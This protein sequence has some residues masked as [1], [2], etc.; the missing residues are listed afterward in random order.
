M[1]CDDYGPDL[2]ASLLG[3][4]DADAA[5]GLAE[6]L[7]LC[8]ACSAEA[9]RCAAL[10]EAAG[11]LVEPAPEAGSLDAIRAAIDE[12]ERVGTLLTALAL[13]QL[14]GA[15]LA[16]AQALVAGDGAARLEFDAI[17][18]LAEGSRS[19]EAPVP[20]PRVLARLK[21]ALRDEAD[22][23][24]GDDDA[25]D[26]DARRAAPSPV[27]R[28]GRSSR[29]LRLVL[30]LVAAAALIV[31]AVILPGEAARSAIVIKGQLLIRPASGSA[32]DDWA[33]ATK[34]AVR[35]RVGDELQA[36]DGPVEL[37][38]RCDGG[39]A[40]SATVDQHPADTVVDLRLGPGARLHRT[41]AREF[42]LTAGGV[43][44]HAGRFGTT[45]GTRFVLRH[46]RSAVLVEGTEFDAS[47]VDGR[48][49]VTVREGSVLLTVEPESGAKKS[50][51]IAAGESGLADGS[52]ILH[53]KAGDVGGIQGFLTPRIV[54]TPLATTLRRDEALRL[55]VELSAGAGGPVR[56]VPFEDSVPLFA[57][58]LKGPGGEKTVKLQDVMLRGE[59]EPVSATDRSRLLEPGRP[60]RLEFEIPR[61]E[62]DPGAWTVTVLYTSYRAHSR[63]REWLGRVESAPAAVEVTE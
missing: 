44:I 50:A 15:E 21:D 42:E 62:L 3:E 61:L 47:A 40:D 36:L 1:T 38:V 6:H 30:P 24:D 53:G 16:Q 58:R 12:E 33:D 48:L 57:V 49:G 51:R 35:F 11:E 55:S 23:G 8:A 54:A 45:D 59:T 17:L 34:G 18:R 7:A 43:N 39:D 25:S 31:A 9:E 60:Y 46:G 52:R 37:R 41:G 29:V 2:V 5:R 22:R 10:L 13:G 19:L 28:N 32:T 26:D 27:R 14:E 4:L 20:S 63:G 56:I